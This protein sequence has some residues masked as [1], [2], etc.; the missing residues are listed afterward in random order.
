MNATSRILR[1]LAWAPVAVGV[2]TLGWILWHL[3]QLATAAH[4]NGDAAAPALIAES[5]GRDPLGHTVLGDVSSLSTLLAYRAT[6]WAPAHRA[7]WAAF[8]YAVSLAGVALLA[9]AAWRLAGRWA[10]LTSAAL[11]VG[12]TTDVLFT[13][14]APAFRATTWATMAL[15][16]AVLVLAGARERGGAGALAVAIAAGAAT[17]LAVVSDPLS[18]VVAVVPFTVALLAMATV[19]RARRWLAWAALAFVMSGATTLAFG[20]SMMHGLGLSTHTEGDAYF[21]RAGLSGVPGHFGQWWRSVVALFTGSKGDWAPQWWLWP[22]LVVALAAII[23][24]PVVTVVAWRRTPV[25]GPGTARGGAAERDASQRGFWTFWALVVLALTAAFVMSGIPDRTGGVTVDRYLVP[26]VIA[27]AATLP[28]ALVRPGWRRT[29]GAVAALLL[30]LPGVVLLWQDDLVTRREAY[31]QVRQA[32]AIAAWL[33]GQGAVTGY[34]DYF[35][36]LAM[37][38]QEGIDVRPAAP[39]ADGHGMCPTPINTRQ[40]WY[41]RAPGRS[42]LILD[43]ALPAGVDLAAALRGMRMPRQVAR[44][45]F[46]GIDV[47]VLAGD[48]GVAGAPRAPRRPPSG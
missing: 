44:R 16:A 29:T 42:F 35:D 9:L 17:G 30:M 22:S 41:R 19:M 13:Q 23:A 5:L 11:A 4:W 14:V 15:L 45:R 33:R 21:A 7:L 34:S 47:V 39:C 26:L 31:P 1:G 38:Y 25:R 32:P 12:V 10:G 48:P 8:P 36:A 28:V 24:I 2:A 46:E 37:T 18:L 27:V 40:A 6:E 20:L 43:P 3:D